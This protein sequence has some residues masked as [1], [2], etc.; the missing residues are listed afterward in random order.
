MDIRECLPKSATYNSLV[1]IIGQTCEIYNTRRSVYIIIGNAM[2]KRD[3]RPVRE[4]GLRRDLALKTIHRLCQ[5]C[6]ADPTAYL[7]ISLPTSLDK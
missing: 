5:E 3:S 2:Y 4:H 6:I 7:V 1:S